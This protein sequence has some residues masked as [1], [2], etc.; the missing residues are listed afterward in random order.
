MITITVKNIKHIKS[1]D[2]GGKPWTISEITTDNGT[3]GTFETLTLGKTYEV[4]VEP[5]ENPQYNDMIKLIREVDNETSLVGFPKQ[6]AAT[7]SDME[8]R[9]EALSHAINLHLS[10]SISFDKVGEYATHYFN[11]LKIGQWN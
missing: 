3:Y 9:S 5:N 4:D 7:S 6:Q 8:L 1:G 11:Y 10:G 2:R